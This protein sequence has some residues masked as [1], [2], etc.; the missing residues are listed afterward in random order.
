MK[1][2]FLLTLLAPVLAAGSL[3]AAAADY[4]LEIDGIK[5]ESGDDRH[6]QAIAIDSFSWGTTNN[7][8]SAGGGGGAGKV[9]FQDMHFTAKVS[10]AGPQLLLASATG[11]HYSRVTLT[12]RK[13]GGVVGEYQEYYHIQLEDVLISSYSISASGSEAGDIVPTDQFSLNFNKVTISYTGLDGTVTTGAAVRTPTTT[14]P[15]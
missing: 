7:A 14:I 15:Q 8:A 13:A 4:L 1:R 3:H 6:V 11:S 5:G 12:M 9:V 2:S 10:K